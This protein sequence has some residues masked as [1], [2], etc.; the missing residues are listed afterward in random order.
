MLIPSDCSLVLSTRQQEAAE[1]EEKQDTTRL[2]L[3]YNDREEEELN[4]LGNLPVGWS[5]SGGGRVVYRGH[6]WE[7]HWGR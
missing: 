7:G 3:E 2:V 6:S 4:A 5:Q 1:L